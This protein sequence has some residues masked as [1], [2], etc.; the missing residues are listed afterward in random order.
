M[1]RANSVSWQ[2]GVTLEPTSTGDVAM[3][4][5]AEEESS[6]T[7]ATIVGVTLVVLVAIV[8]V[9]LLGVLIDCRQQKLM[10]KK[11]GEVTKAK[12][13]KNRR[14]S[15]HPD[16]DATTIVDNMEEAEL[17]VPP[18]EILKNIP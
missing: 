2:D 16:G 7:V 1:D 10:E 13:K 14:A 11:M 18:A 8:L 3:S 12:A 5:I 4:A 9:F 15:A 17:S 6:L